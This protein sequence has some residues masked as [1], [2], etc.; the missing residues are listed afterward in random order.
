[1]PCFNKETFVTPAKRAQYP[2]PT[3]VIGHS[4]AFT[5][6]VHRAFTG[7]VDLRRRFC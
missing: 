1:M 6:G 4:Q 2:A 3:F 5:A 7:A